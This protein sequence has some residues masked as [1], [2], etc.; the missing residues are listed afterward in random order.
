MPQAE[1]YDGTVLDFEDGT[2]DEVIHRVARDQTQRLRDAEASQ[3]LPAGVQ[4]STAEGGRGNTN[5][6]TVDQPQPA[7]EP[8]APKPRWNTG[9]RGTAPVKPP[10][11]TGPTFDDER[12]GKMLEGPAGAFTQDQIDEGSIAPDRLEAVRAERAARARDRTLGV[13]EAKPLSTGQEIAANVRDFTQNP[14]ARGAV[15]GFSELGQVGVGA[16]RLAAD[17][18]GADSVAKFAGEASRTA[19]SIG[20]ESTRDLKGNDKLIADV[21][22]S[23][24]NSVP[25]MALGTAG[26]PALRGLFVQSAMQEYNTGRD[27]GFD[28]APSLARSGIFGAAEALGEMFSL[29]HASNI[30]KGMFKGMDAHEMAVQAA[31][32]LL[33][34]APGEQLTTLMEF[35]A[36]KV[37]PAAQNPEAGLAQYLE[38]AGETLRL[39]VA[40]SAVMGAPAAFLHGKAALKKADQ[41]IG[42]SALNPAERAAVEKFGANPYAFANASGFHVDP[43]LVSDPAKAQRS[44]TSAIFENMAAQYGIPAGAVSRAKKVAESLPL[45]QLGGFYQRFV[46]ALQKRDQ[47]GTPV[48]DHAM[49]TLTAGPVVLPEEHEAA[50]AEAEKKAEAQQKEA[51]QAAA[52]SNPAKTETVSQK[53][54]TPA[55]EDYT[56]LS[57]ASPVDEAAHAA[58]PSPKNDLPEPSDAQKDAGNYSKGHARIAGL[59]ISIEN[60]EGSVRRSKAD[61]PVKWETTMRHHYGYIRGTVGM[62]TVDQTKPEQ[63]D[64]FIK[65]GT[66]EDFAGD[67]FVVDQVDPKTGKPDEHKVLLGFD[68][69]E[70][71]R[72]AYQSNYQKGWNGL[73][74]ITATPMADFKVWVKGDTSKPFSAGA[75]VTVKTDK[76]LTLQVAKA[77]NGKY[78]ATVGGK[79]VGSVH[80]TEV[81]TGG[82]RVTGVDVSP[83][84]RRQGVA[85][86]L[87]DH[88]EKVVLKQ[89]LKTGGSQSESGAA[90]R[91]AREAKKA[92]PVTFKTAKGSVYQ[93]SG[94]T[95]TRNKAAR[96]DVGHE[97]DSGPK[98]P[99]ERTFYVDDAGADALSLFQTRGGKKSIQVGKGQ[100]GVRHE[101]GKDAGK[102]ERRTVTKIHDAP[103]VGLTPVELW[104]G[105]HVAHFGNKITEVSG[106]QHQPDVSTPAG[107]PAGGADG[108]GA[109][110]GGSRGTVGHQPAGAGGRRSGVAAAPVPSVR[111]PAPVGAGGDTNAP[112]GRVIARVGAAPRHAK[113]LELRANADGTV[114][115]WFEGHELLDYDSGDPVR[116]PADATDKQALDAVRKSGAITIKQKFYPVKAKGESDADVEVEQQEPAAEPAAQAE[117]QAAVTPAEPAPAAEP[118]RRANTV[119]RKRVAEMTEPELRAAL[120]T[121]DLTG[122]RNRRWMEEHQGEYSHVVAFD[123]DSLKW[124]NDNLGH[125]SGD[126]L[127][128]AWGEALRQAAPETGSRVGGDEFF[129]FANSNIESQKIVETVRTILSRAIVAA[130]TPSGETVEVRGIGV[131]FGIA[132]DRKAADERLNEHKRQREAAG[133]RAG[134]GEAPPG[135]TRTPREPAQGQQDQAGA[136]QLEDA[137]TEEVKSELMPATAAPAPAPAAVAPRPRPAVAAK[138]Q[139]QAEALARYFRPGNVVLGYGG[140]DEVLE[141][142]SA[143][144]SEDG[145]GWAVHVH[146]VRKTDNGWERI[147]KPQDSRW[148]S[149]TPSARDFSTGPESVLKPAPAASV[150]YTEPRADGKPFPNAPDRGA[151]ASVTSEAVPAAPAPEPSKPKAKP[152]VSKNTVFTEDAAAAARERLRAQRSKLRKDSGVLDFQD[153][154]DGLTLAG[155][156]IERGART[157]A[158]YSRAML[159]DLGDEFKPYLKSWY[160][161]AYHDPRAAA[162]QAEMTPLDKLDEAEPKEAPA[163]EEEERPQRAA[164]APEAESMAADAAPPAPLERAGR[165][166]E[167]Q[168]ELIEHV[169]QKGKTLRG[170][171]RTDLTFKQAE[172]VDA[173]TFKKNGGYFIREK[174][175]E[176]LETRFPPGQA[177]SEAAAPLRTPEPEAGT[178]ADLTRALY[179]R[180]K[181]DEMPADNFELK[182]IVTEFDGKAPDAMRMKQAQ[183]AQEVAIVMASRDV[184]AR[185]QGPRATFDMLT[186]LY[187]SQPLLNV[188]TSTSIEN[189]AYSTPA[190][191]AYLASRMARATPTARVYE[192]TAGNGMLLI[193]SDPGI[194]LVNEINQDRAAA[195]RAQG[196]T[197]TTQDATVAALVPPKSADAV[198]TN[199]PFG[200]LPVK[201]KVDGY[202]IG[203]IDHLIAARALDAMADDGRAVLILGASKTVGGMSNDDLIFFN[204]LRARYKVAGQFEVDGDLYRRQGAGWPVR[205]ILIAGRGAS[206]ERNPHVKVT[207][208]TNWSEV[209]ELGHEAALAAQFDAVEPVDTGAADRARAGDVAHPVP[210]SAANPPAGS[211]RRAATGSQASPADVTRERAGAVGDRGAAAATR[212]G[213]RPG[214]QRPA[215]KPAAVAVER[216]V[217]RGR[218]VQ[219]AGDAGSVGLTDAENQ[220]QVRYIPRSSNQD[221]GVLIPVN[222][223]GPTQQSLDR[224]E[225]RVGDIDEFVQ[226]ELG[227]ESVEQ[228]H[229]AL[230]GLQV[231]SVGAAI[232]EIKT[233]KGVIIADQTGIGKGRQAAAVIRWA[234]RTGR[235]PVFVTVKPSLFTDM[236]GDLHD[237]GSDDVQPFIVNV[238]A[239]IK[240][241]GDDK[242]F[243]NRSAGHR[244]TLQRIAE[245]GA[246]PGESNA[247]FMTYSQINVDNVQRAAVRALAPRAVF[248]LDESHNAGGDSNTGEFIREALSVASGVTYLSATYAKR[249]D[250]MPVYFKTDIGEA[251][252]DDQSL[253]D[254]MAAG[255]LPLQTVVSNN[256]VKAGQLFRR[257]RSYDGVSIETR[258]DVKHRAEHEKLSDTTTQALRAIVAADA[259]FHDTFVAEMKK[260]LLAAGE[261]AMEAGN[262]AN[263]SVNHTEFSSVVHNFVRQM[264]LGLKAQEAA[265]D[266]VEAIKAGKKPLIAVE[267][268]MGSFLAEYAEANGLKSGDPL[269]VFDYRNVL[270][271][272]LAR[273]RFIMLQKAN[274]DKEREEIPLNKLDPETR[275]LYDQAQRLIDGLR[276]DIPVSPID[277]MRNVITQ[278]GHSVMEIT[279]RNLAVDYSDPKVPTLD[280]VDAKEQKDKVRTTRMFNAGEL[281]AIIMNVAGSTGISLHASEKF[282]DQRKRRMIVAQAAQDINIFMQML[283]RIHRTGQ[284]ELPEYAILSVDLPAEKRPTALLAK[285]MKSL[286]ANTSSNTESATS[287]QAV[288]MLNKYGDQIIGQY[289]ADNPELSK[290]LG[291]EPPEEA[292]SAQEDIARKATGRLALMPVAVQEAFYADVEE[293]YTALL[294]YLNKTN[295]NELEPRTFDF[296]AKEL[297]SAVIFEGQNKESLFGEDATY[298]EYSVKAQGKAM[299]P[300]EIRTVMDQHLEGK[301]SKAHA[302]ELR[303]RLEAAFNTYAAGL[304]GEQLAIAQAVRN[305][306]SD[307]MAEHPIGSAWRVDINGDAYNAVV[308]NLRSTHRAAGNPYAMSKVQVSIAVNGSLRSVTVPGTQFR[309]IEVSTLS[310]RYTVEQLFREGPKDERDTVKII[311][312]NLLGAYGEIKSSRGTIISFTRA[313]GTTDQG[314]LLPKK[315]TF[316]ENVQ[317]DYRLRTADD[318]L[319]FLTQGQANDLDKIG[320]ASRDGTIRVTPNDGGIKI[321]VPK[322][323]ARGGKFFMDP[324]LRAALGDFVSTAAFMRASTEDPDAAR[325]ALAAVMKKVALYAM[326][327]M[328]DEARTLLGDA[329]PTDKTPGKDALGSIKRLAR[330]PALPPE[331]QKRGVDMFNEL[332]TV[333]GRQ[334]AQSFLEAF[335]A[336]PLSEGNS[337]FA[338]LLGHAPE[339]HEVP[340]RDRFE[341]AYFSMPHQRLIKAKVD[342]FSDGGPITPA[343]ALFI[344]DLMQMESAVPGLNENI[345]KLMPDS[346]KNDDAAQEDFGTVSQSRSFD[347]MYIYNEHYRETRVRGQ[348][349]DG[350][351]KYIDDVLDKGHKVVSIKVTNTDLAE[352][353]LKDPTKLIRALVEISGFVRDSNAAAFDFIVENYSPKLLKQEQEKE[354][355]RLSEYLIA[356]ASRGKPKFDDGNVGASGLDDPSGLAQRDQIRSV[357][358]GRTPLAQAQVDRLARSMGKD[359][360]RLTPAQRE[361]FEAAARGLANG[362]ASGG[363]SLDAADLAAW[364]LVKNPDLLD[365]A[366]VQ[367]VPK[368]Q[369]L[370]GFYSPTQ[371]VI[372]IAQ[373]SEGAADT[374]VHE[375]L[376]HTER[377][378]PV[379]VQKQIR[380]AWSKDLNAAI[381]ASDADRATELQ[382]LRDLAL[383]GNFNEAEQVFLGAYKAELFENE[384]YQFLNPSEYWAENGARIIANRRTAEAGGWIEEALQ[385]LRDLGQKLRDLLDL[386]SDAPV[387]RAIR[388]LQTSSNGD[389]VSAG[390]VRDFGGAARGDK[391]ASLRRVDKDRYT[392]EQREAL[393]RAGIGGPPTIGEKLRTYYT[394]AAAALQDN[395]GRQFQQGYLDQFTGIALAV[396]RDVGNLP[397]EQDPYVAAR[398]ANGGTSSVMRGLL[399]HGQAMW[400]ENGQ[401]LQ[402]KPGTQGLLDILAPLGDDLNDFFGWMVGNRAARLMKE[403]R[404]RNLSE[405]QIKT[406]QDL[407]NGKEDK[408]RT[409]AM[410]YSQFKRS[411]LDI[412]EHAG[413]INAESRK[414]WDMADYIPFYREID[415]KAVFTATGKRGLA[416]QSSGIRTLKG[417]EAA[418][419]DPVENILMNFSRLID[420]SLKNNALA[421]TV[422]VLETAE[423]PAVER[424][425]YSFTPEIIPADQVR[426][427]LEQAGTPKEVLDVIPPEAFT[428]MAKMWAIQAPSDPDVIRIMKDGRPEFYRVHDPLL[429]KSAT[430]FVPFDFP[431]LGVMRAFK[432]ILTQGVT[433]AP[434]FWVRNWLRD[435]V[436]SQLVGR[437]GFSPGKSVSGIVKSYTESGAFEAM[438]FSGSSFQSGQVNAADPQGTA[439][440]TRRALRQRGMNAASS[441][442]FVASLLDT[443]AKLWEHYK[444]IGE[445]VENANREAMHEA[446]YKAKINAGASAGTAATAAAYE[447]KDMMDFTLRG[448]SPVYQLMAD[449]L[450]FFNAR[451]QGLYRLGR[452]D[453]KRLAMYGTLLMM[454]AIAL[455]WAND[456]RDEYDALPDWDKDNYWHF[457]IDGKHFRMPKPFELGVVFGTV[458]ERIWRYIRGQDSGKKTAKQVANAVIDQFAFDPVPQMVRPALNA[459]ANKDTF[460]QR[461]IEGMADEGKLPSQRYSASTSAT[462]VAAVRSLNVPVPVFGGKAL[463]NIGLSPKKL[464]YLVNG[465]LGTMGVYALSV[466]DM[467]VRAM[468]GRPPQ[469][470]ARLD[471]IPL[472]KDFYQMSPPRSTV[473]EADLYALRKDTEEVYRSVLALAREGK[474]DEA[475]VLAKEHEVKLAVRGAVNQSADLLSKLNKQRDAIY[476]S[477]TMTPEQK[478]EK[479]DQILTKKAQ[480]TAK[481]MKNPV[482]R[483]AQ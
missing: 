462:A 286:N 374:L 335:N 358:L 188:R 447:S 119:E 221:K 285:K 104:K 409:A 219:P 381:A 35:L 174:H 223:A 371:K 334:I 52:E 118:E 228:M 49:A 451:V 53:S 311:T 430:S 424:I 236:Y 74:A 1:L 232:H 294:E 453:P 12:A 205:V 436:A 425:G 57:E 208:A 391:L 201:V 156:H 66:A 394:R 48:D 171:V 135:T 129:A 275:A 84:M 418:L 15:A 214:E 69:L 445:A 90:F 16:T 454:A 133:E 162:F 244:D 67:V 112:V 96:S 307:F 200:G 271:R 283:G 301:T 45:D 180:I 226:N 376:H 392:P 13:A 483:S 122:L 351:R 406:L 337:E 196:F 103:A 220:F 379:E 109:E 144:E 65:P 414:V 473:F 466:S 198:I 191:L 55:E 317:H 14:V 128:R 197:V 127:L 344:A 81:P 474:K 413:L 60:P 378:L 63:V 19:Q 7:E 192:P 450:P 150:I 30:V 390:M 364:F 355:K 193:A 85:T 303:A 147:G 309:K 350:D 449:V 237:I 78:V 419:N 432:R 110:S 292:D 111:A 216:P 433:S 17:L 348:D 70:E 165:P 282:R 234:V 305:S 210:V 56:G 328:A 331:M 446:T 411:V 113:P 278:A 353:F 259:H 239:S 308:T 264:L 395:W 145:R 238:D 471:D 27:S 38:Q 288:D 268:T 183:E 169:T 429:L 479:L 407:G 452:A 170:I 21:T 256:L 422:R 99:S 202:T 270:S 73:G 172:Q 43:P 161:A 4:P 300:A 443:P 101:G 77:F 123:A 368:G 107:Q 380:L 195:L 255:G 178:Q 137:G 318:A 325:E 40:Q 478:R 372:S 242:L 438:L 393:R 312:G 163:A 92:A 95:T 448:S 315:F 130:E 287:V 36:D 329:R 168:S 20:S 166:A 199:P 304:G 131:S 386:P 39:S 64:A 369:R 213:V 227:Y 347:P 246:L 32:H 465:Y 79:Q 338:E 124:V 211:D 136:G 343:K 310:S 293:Q 367:I 267:N 455:A 284:V 404:E 412:A 93:V 421:K 34:D 327:S 366:V 396:R 319:T 58:A 415:D 333:E 274:G 314:I 477:T 72:D 181:A 426:K 405:A 190:P 298:G 225:D 324:Q 250:N 28:V 46:V 209:Y 437:D 117:Q 8:P 132:T 377:M 148:H 349:P 456:D 59:D 24:M 134:R 157:F 417:G 472:I 102:I 11:A 126:L 89:P 420:A 332:R 76:G 439:I 468:E 108:R 373:G 82:F 273:T 37:G 357:D 321:Q 182:R 360:D 276:L 345:Y 217:D 5:P 203:Q 100:A 272:A 71:A 75:P 151:A 224:M 98:E 33:K 155:Y 47:V 384:D 233:G 68:S 257:E 97:G 54:E 121:D 401:H 23:I 416:G 277:W 177:K 143:A 44:K 365:D 258:A 289:L 252:S 204:W 440:A 261:R 139:Q 31:K 189:Q 356:N 427:R 269:G 352:R 265:D 106:G 18:V 458:P 179:E 444:K 403:G 245:S 142:R 116:I 459:W 398:L 22:S 194:S 296:D 400:A 363:L 153:M 26:G 341:R 370:A 316:A 428:G 354:A 42:W 206:A 475:K 215:A 280:S 330:S 212:V 10:T 61:S 342:E 469:P 154:L 470:A 461:P 320:I 423:S 249:P 402:K 408:F 457:W 51:E 359:A 297:T 138:G 80:F 313:D 186:R 230:M 251:T 322:S 83:E 480:L 336:Q 149:T 207:R 164:P 389:F 435:S 25:A 2:P 388:L 339:Q 146:H 323:K 240:G 29:P 383:A 385:W 140:Y 306:S 218:P 175:L 3:P 185:K 243:A 9:G 260:D 247:V 340:Y 362:V 241:Q 262:M 266:A 158:A 160:A 467:A 399:L 173:Y 6:P 88:L 460:R 279:G 476:A 91:D 229:E 302:A 441:D 50:A 482:V 176:A 387:L 120:H 253:M 463:D 167:A 431:G 382:R 94:T 481:T 152:E 263:E 105:G 141:F 62:D 114:T 410:A 86:A 125:D 222:M 361:K 187:E 115:P 87:Y 295:Q 41:S 434:P 299:T 248:I 442:A 281:D 235:I 346:F 397:I 231:D 184:V 375:I 159:E 326:P 291:I 464:E 290:A 254:A